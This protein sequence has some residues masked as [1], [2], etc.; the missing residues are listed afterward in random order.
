VTTAHRHWLLLAGSTLAVAGALAMAQAILAARTWRL[1][2]TAG[3]R[4]VLSPYARRILDGLTADVEIT[5]FVRPDDP[6]N[7]DIEDLLRRV[8]AASP[9]VRYQ[10][11]DVNRNPAL[12][13][14][15][16][17]DAYGATVVESQGRRREFTHPTEELLA[18][19]IVQVTQPGS[20]RV[21]FLAGHGER[22]LRDREDR[23]GYAAARVALMAE[24]YEVTELS[25]L[26][27]A[28]VPADAAVLVVASPRRD[29]LTAE[30]LKLDAYLRGGGNLLVLLDP[31]A[32]PG[33]AALLRRYGVAVSEELVLDPENRLFAGDYLTMLVPERAAQHPVSAALSAP[34]LMSQIRPV[35][36][37][38]SEWALATIELLRTAPE[39]WRTADRNVLRTGAGEFVSGRDVSGPV[40][41]GVSALVRN[42]QPHGRAGRLLVY[43]D[44]NFADNF[45]LGYLGNRDLLLNSVN[46]LA[47]Q[48]GLIA[49]RPADK[50]PGVEQFFVSNR[51]GR[52]LL[53]LGTVVQPGLVLALGAAVVWRRRWRG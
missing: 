16:G 41:V 12:A 38:E 36:A 4:Y 52:L 34:A 6:R 17:I 47:G 42:E 5:T 29:L 51:Q 14:E 49:S 31:G 30:L 28:E 26:G 32:A 48:E 23:Q 19:A 27:D 50:T 13:R 15:Y 1:D 2:L 22:D 46:W 37:V 45:F 11:V 25:L 33:L 43:G 20:W 18:A 24:R 35:M 44:A 39:S 21:A 7:P 9:R 40:P 53:W 3:Q 10:V 8:R